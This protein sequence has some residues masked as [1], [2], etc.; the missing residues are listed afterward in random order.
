VLDLARAMPV[1]GDPQ[2]WGAFAA[3]FSE[4]DGY[5]REDGAGREAFRK[6][7]IAR[8]APV[9]ARLGWTPQAGEPA[10]AAILR[11]ALI[12]ALGVLGERG[13][14]EEAR[15]RYAAEAT[16]PS[17]IPGSLRKTILGVV[18]RHADAATW[19]RLHAAA[20]AEKTPLVKDR[21][22]ALLSSVADET[23]ARRALELALTPE[24]GA[25]NSA[26][27]ISQV[28]KGH[29][30]LA[31][32]FAVAHRDAVDAKVDPTSGS[33]YYARLAEAS[34][35]PEMVAKLR[36]YAAV[37]LD[38]KSRGETERVCAAVA[39]NIRVRAQALPSIAAWLGKNAD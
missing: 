27:M 16:D 3:I 31:F 22:Y 25:T 30:D 8:L 24:P 9:F 12:G 37:H 36:A 32:D 6:F 19:D 29:P 39:E 1:D 5:A 13:I 7:A 18:A 26:E 2:L 33:R 10:Q 14:V 38:P 21:L 35:D 23:L 28:A 4:V 20:I 34:E 11:E 17:A 15:R